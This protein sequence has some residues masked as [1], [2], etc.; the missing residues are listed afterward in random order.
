MEKRKLKVNAAE[1]K[2]CTDMLLYK[3]GKIFWFLII[4]VT[5][6]I[7]RAKDSEFKKKKRGRNNQTDECCIEV[8]SRLEEVSSGAK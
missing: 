6:K 3:Q 2:S 7:P 4:L 1:I 5:L 8:V